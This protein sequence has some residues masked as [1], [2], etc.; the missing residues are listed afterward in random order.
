[1]AL[2]STELQPDSFNDDRKPLP[3]PPAVAITPAVALPKPYYLENGLRRVA[4][5]HFTYNTFCKQ[6]WRGREILDIFAAEFR[7]R[8]KQYYKEAIES[9]Q[10]MINGKP[11]NDIHT[12]VQN[13]DVISHT[14]HRHVHL[15]TRQ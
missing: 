10:I 4:P 7:D 11:C 3:P 9:G 1:M 12:I 2:M 5:Y 13:G 6:R 8:T 15:C 14:L